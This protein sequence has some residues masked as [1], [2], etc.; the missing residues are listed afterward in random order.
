MV[1]LNKALEGAA[2]AA[3]AASMT[4]LADSLMQASK[5]AASIEEQLSIAPNYQSIGD[6]Y[7]ELDNSALFRGH[8]YPL[9]PSLT[10]LFFFAVVHSLDDQDFRGAPNEIKWQ[11][12]NNFH[13][14]HEVFAITNKNDAHAAL[15][16]VREQGEGGG[17]GDEYSHYVIFQRLLATFRSTPWKLYKVPKNPTT[18]EYPAGSYI[19]K[20]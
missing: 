5:V 8:I 14:R 7:A 2:S 3:S 18:A 13:S 1:T 9:R 6:V 19:R 15:Q 20:V 4:L 17:A 10:I 12:E 16:K 11:F